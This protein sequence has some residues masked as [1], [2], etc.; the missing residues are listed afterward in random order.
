MF[1]GTEVGVVQHGVGIEDADDADAVEVETLGNHLRA[2]EQVGAPGAE[3]AD[4]PFVGIA[5]AGGVEVHAA[6]TRFGED[7]AHVGLNLLRAVAA[8][9][10]LRSATGGAGHG[11]LVDGT[12]VVAYQLVHLAVQRQRDVTVLT[13]GHPA[14]L[15]TLYHRGIAAAVLEEDGLLATFQGFT[16]TGE[17]QWRERAA[18]HLAALQVAGV[19]HLYLGQLD[20]G[21]ALRQLYIAVL[22]LL[23]IMI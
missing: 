14:A 2:D 23:R 15:L 4:E 8:G 9:L 12:A 6:D 21:M 16:Q 20:A 18:H 17:Q 22:T 5:G 3:V 13:V 1:V 10:Q 19:Y 7:V 11:H